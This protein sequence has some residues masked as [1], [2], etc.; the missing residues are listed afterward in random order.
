VRRFRHTDEWVGALV[1]AA[2]LLFVGAVLEAGLLRD[3]FR[4]VSNLRILLPQ[5]GVS[6]LSVG[7]DIEVLGVHAGNVRRIV[8]NPNQQIYAD[9]DI[10]RQAEAF[11]RRDS[12]A[13][14]RRQFGVVGA[15]YVD[16]SRGVSA[17]LD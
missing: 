4:P 8:L 5:S 15:A 10:E 7:A 9:A 3:W 16:I 12:Q 14:I 2:V 13:V 1:L 17:P 6:G 11:I